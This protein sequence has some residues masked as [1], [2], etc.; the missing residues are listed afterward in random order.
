MSQRQVRLDKLQRLRDAEVPPYPDRFEKTHSLAEAMR[1]DVGVSDVALAGR[2][3]SR[4]VMGK[5]TFAHLVDMSGKIQLSVQ[6]DRVGKEMYKH[7]VKRFDLGDFVGV[8][9]SMI[10]T[11]TGELT[12]RADSIEFLGKT[13]RPMPE[14][15]HGM[16]DQE[17]RYRRRY[18]DLLV[19]EKTRE[20]F[21]LRTRLIRTIRDFLDAHEFFEVETPVLQNKASGALARPFKAHHNSLDLEVCLRIAPETYL[22]RLIVGGFDRVYEFARCFRNEGMDASHLQDFTML[23]YYVAY[24]NYEDNM[25]FTQQLFQH[26]LQQVLGTDKLSFRGNEL[27]FSGEWPRVTFAELIQRDCGID[28]AAFPTAETLLAEIRR[29]D[30]H[31]EHKQP[32]TLGRGNLIDALYKKMCRPKLIQPTFLT[33]HPTDISPLARKNDANPDITDR[34]QLVVAGWEVVNAYSE[35]V[36]PIDQRARMEAQAQAREK[37]D[38][39]ALEVDEDYLLAMEYGMPPMSGWGMGIDRLVALL[40]DLENLRDT[41]FFPLMRPWDHEQL[42]ALADET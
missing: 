8:R 1:L 10:R 37:G 22:K 6:Q 29:Q 7:L 24:W 19:N 9:G 33:A 34:F 3:T 30:I 27:D 15:W 23:E 13:L 2:M 20:V 41:V 39:E 36:D 17:L 28:L 38:E 21:K 5:M 42:A 11:R 12:L 32:E 14:K 25:R 16:K 4:R 18:L 31:L 26:F 40:L 35:L